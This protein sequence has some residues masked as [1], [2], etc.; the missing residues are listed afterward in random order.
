MT[1][2]L[3]LQGLPASG[4]STYRR[5]FI[6]VMF[7]KGP[8]RYVA[9]DEIRALF[10]NHFDPKHEKRVFTVTNWCIKTYLKHGFD[11]I[12]D[13][14]NVSKRRL[15]ELEQFANNAGAVFEVKSFMDV[16]VEDC[17]KRDAQR[18]LSPT[19]YMEHVGK[20]VIERMYYEYWRWQ[21]KP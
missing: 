12:V 2:L 11:V 3:A 15:N 19:G 1:T 9:R 17:F 21:P 8:L 6:D 14:S 16:P 18:T 20:D 7:G 5:E 13:E 4:K 10:G